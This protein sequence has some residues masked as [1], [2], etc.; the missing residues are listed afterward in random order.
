MHY[1]FPHSLIQ[2]LREHYGRDTVFE[3]ARAL[4][5]VGSIMVMAGHSQDAFAIFKK[6]LST[7]TRENNPVPFEMVITMRLIGDACVKEKEYS[8]GLGSYQEAFDALKKS[9]SLSADDIPHEV[10]R[11]HLGVSMCA[12]GLSKYDEA[13]AACQQA[14]SLSTAPQDGQ[15][16]GN[17]SFDILWQRAKILNEQHQTLFSPDAIERTID[18]HDRALAALKLSYFNNEIAAAEK[19]AY[20]F[21]SR[22]L[23]LYRSGQ[24][25]LA[26]VDHLEASRLHGIA[27]K[28]LQTPLGLVFSS[29]VAQCLLAVGRNDEALA[30]W[31]QTESSLAALFPNEKDRCAPLISCTINRAV[32]LLAMGR[33]EDAKSA[34]ASA[35]AL[36]STFGLAAAVFAVQCVMT[37]ASFN[38]Y[39]SACALLYLLPELDYNSGNS[40]SNSV[41]RSFAASLTK[42]VKDVSNDPNEIYQLSVAAIPSCW[43]REFAE[44]LSDPSRISFDSAVQHL[45][46]QL[47]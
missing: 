20:V 21:Q 2:L 10:A 36:G 15:L 47:N 25:E 41:V 32:V 18:A 4:V 19:A 42:L 26:L 33:K 8:N 1:H 37:S 17:I 23:C 46:L 29:N 38:A 14:A 5:N 34:V 27:C 39:L 11:L 44:N 22:A 6:A 45:Q 7:F 3:V 28:G 43:L 9:K 12:L 30:H 13:L 24:H 16:R 40:V 35:K 31:T